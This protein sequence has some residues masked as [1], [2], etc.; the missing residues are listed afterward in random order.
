MYIKSEVS[1]HGNAQCYQQET[2]ACLFSSHML[3]HVHKKSE[4]KEKY[5]W[6]YVM[7]ITSMQQTFVYTRLS[8]SLSI[9][10][11][12]ACMHFPF[13]HSYKYVHATHT[14][15][16]MHVC[17]H[18]STCIPCRNHYACMHWYKYAHASAGCHTCTVMHLCMYACSCV[19]MYRLTW[20]PHTHTH[21]YMYTLVV[22]YT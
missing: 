19:N 15:T 21:V 22:I 5:T 12:I 1:K 3:I 6:A 9:Y 7:Y 20:H 14:H 13:T 16:C 4:T 17:S 2:R 11:Y 18:M 8:L 10:I